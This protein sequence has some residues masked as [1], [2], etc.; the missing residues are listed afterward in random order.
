MLL[1]GSGWQYRVELAA[2]AKNQVRGRV[3]AREQASGEPHTQITLYQALLRGERFEWVLQKCT[4]VGVV[5][6]TPVV[7][8]RSLV[9]S[10][11]AGARKHERWARIVREAAEQSRRALLPKLAA[12]EPFEQACAAASQHDLAVLLWEGSAPPLKQVLRE[13]ATS[14]TIGSVA[15]FSGPEGGFT[16]DEVALA[17]GHGVVSASL[18]PRILRAETAPL[19]AA[20]LLLYELDL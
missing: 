6:F 19:V 20:S 13:Q 15:L 1:D 5:A 8:E 14:A 10:D 4:E 16:P 2:L 7:C 12:P 9:G 11:D 17:Q 18:G 3:L